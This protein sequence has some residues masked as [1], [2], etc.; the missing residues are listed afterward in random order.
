MENKAQIRR[1]PSVGDMLLLLL[2][3]FVSQMLLGTILGA[4]GLSAPATSP[5]DAVDIETYMNEQES[6][7]RYTAFVYPLSMLF[8]IAVLWLYVRLRGGKRAIHIRHSA[9]GFNPS[10][11]LVGVLWL[12]SAQIVL[13]PLMSVLPQSDNSGL[14]R[15]FWACFTAVISSAV[16]EEL[17]CRGLIFETLHKRWGAKTSILFSSLFFGLIHLDLATAIVAMVAG[18]IFGVLYVRTSSLYTTIIIHSVNNAMAFALICFGVGD[19]SLYDII[20]GGEIYWAVYGV[21]A[22]IFLA[23]SIEAYFKVFRNNKRLMANDQ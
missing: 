5:I 21:A 6:L 17:L 15:G 13:E 18:M 7:G 2:L 22:A 11:V 12:L 19:M 9:S 16:L 20:G 4:L 8:S 14:G 3:F 10:V 23:C 1:F